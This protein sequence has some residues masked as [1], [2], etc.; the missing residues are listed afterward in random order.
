MHDRKTKGAGK[1]ALANMLRLCLC[2]VLLAA[3]VVPSYA[4]YDTAYWNEG[5]LAQIRPDWMKDLDGDLRLSQLSLPGTHDSMAH[6]SNLT[7]LDVT[8]TQTMHLYDQLISGIRVL[9]IRLFYEPDG[10][11]FSIYHG[12]IYLGYNFDTVMEIVYNYLRTY[13]SE[14]I[15]MRLQQEHSKAS[16]IQMYNLFAR[17]YN[18]YRNTFYQAGYDENPRLKDMR[19]KC[20]ILSD[21]AGLHSYGIR[22][23]GL[24]IQDD[25]QLNTNWDA[26]AKW[27]KIRNHLN[28][29]NNSNGNQVYMNYLSGSGGS[30]PYFVASGHS[31]PGTAADRLVTGLTEPGFHGW[32][33]DYP[34]GAWF[35]V[36]GT[37]FFEGTN[38]LTADYLSNHRLEY[39]GII[40]ADFPGERL[41]NAIIACNRPAVEVFEDDGYQGRSAGLPLGKSNFWDWDGIGNDKISS[42]KVRDGYK[43]TLYKDVDAKG[44]SLVLTSDSSWVGYD[45]N[46]R[47]SSAFVEKI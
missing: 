29:A 13:P 26:Y 9:D 1:R 10:S 3:M 6:K 31:S 20:V 11:G 39:C 4:H 14:V 8:R 12:P 47:F 40:M 18:Q 22:Y 7:G 15:F 44:A 27:E 41:I 45:W 37:I 2:M 23:R 33:P 30:F 5:V 35:G 34:R 17:Y 19:G 36:I 24:K 43:V 42:I 16:D 32:Y 28:L 46:D 38:T 25:Y 21:C